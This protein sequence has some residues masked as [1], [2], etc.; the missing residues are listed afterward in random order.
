MRLRIVT[1]REIRL[2]VAVR[3]IVAEAPGGAFGMLPNHI[4]YVSQLAAGLL[5]YEGT[6]GRERY[7]GLTQGTLVKQGE[8]VL[9]STRNAILGDDPAAVRARVAE[10]FRRI[11]ETE[12]AERA[13]LARLELELVRQFRELDISP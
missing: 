11:E 5:V 2:D 13:A 7:A 12:R 1:P 3:R 6:D 10:E 9:V 8:E 4:D